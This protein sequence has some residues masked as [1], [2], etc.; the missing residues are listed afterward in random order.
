MNQ[1]RFPVLIF[2]HGILGGRIQNTS[3]IQELASHGY[4]VVGIDHT[5]DASFTIF[6][7]TESIPSGLLANSLGPDGNTAV[8]IRDTG[9]YVRVADVQFVLDE[10]A[11]L[12]A[13]DPKKILAGH[14]DLEKVGVFG[15]SFG[16][17]T[18]M[19]ACAVDDRVRSGLA[20]DGCISDERIE[21]LSKP[22]FIMKM[23]REGEDPIGTKRLSKKCSGPFWDVNIAGTAHGNFTDLAFLTPA[24]RLSMLTGTI[25][26]MRALIIMNAYTL[27]FFDY[28]LLGKASALL[29]GPS[30]E[31]NEV[32]FDSMPKKSSP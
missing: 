22:L 3:Q 2:S 12:N 15:H 21:L 4:V 16:G 31:F 28:T 5:Y 26:P 27:A 32:T 7:P 19:G 1:A 24:H 20:M 23:P 30:A 18:T 17:A 8:K 13:E 14:L 9:I 6:S 10:L 25:E 29:D 11:K